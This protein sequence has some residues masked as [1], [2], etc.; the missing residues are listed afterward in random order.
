MFENQYRKR[1]KKNN[2][3]TQKKQILLVI[4]FSIC[5]Y[6]FTFT[7][8]YSQQNNDMKYNNIFQS[9]HTNV[10]VKKENITI[11]SSKNIFHNDNF[12]SLHSIKKS[13]NRKLSNKNTRCNANYGVGGIIIIADDHARALYEKPIRSMKCYAQ[14]H[15]YSFLLLG[16]ESPKCST[17]RDF[18]FKRHCV[19]LD[20]LPNYDWLAFFDADV[21]IFNANKCIESLMSPGVDIVHEER[22]HNGEVHAGSYIIKN[23]TFA[24]QYLQQWIQYDNDN[25]FNSDNGALHIHLL[26][27]MAHNVEVVQD[28]YN[29]WKEAHDLSLYDKYVGC[30]M[31]YLHNPKAQKQNTEKIRLIR[32][33]HGFVRDLWVTDTVSHIDFFVHA[34]KEHVQFYDEKK[35]SEDQCGTQWYQPIVKEKY[36]VSVQ[37]M[38][39]DIT[40][41]DLSA[42]VVRP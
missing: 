15:G 2:F 14:K 4:I 17:I 23:T 37:S 32:R 5:M 9:L 21:G 33:G 41:A 30:V 25:H 10:N 8:W 26:K 16:P 18:M 42:N 13:E 36:N 34:I 35:E 12:T 3:N 27:Q 39:S 11:F 20:H 6:L 28:C 31:N 40:K 19:V 1:N 29:K 22:F 38:K 7:Q 24:K